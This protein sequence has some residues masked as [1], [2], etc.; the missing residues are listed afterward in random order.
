MGLLPIEK[1]WELISRGVDEIIPEEELKAK[2]KK[3]IDENMPLKVKLGCD[4]SR[5][6]LHIGHGVVLRKLRHLQD[7][8]HNAILDIG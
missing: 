7:L 4:P 5:P 1:Q 6:D 8:V 3:S 2:L